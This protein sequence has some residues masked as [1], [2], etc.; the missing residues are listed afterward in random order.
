MNPTTDITRFLDALSRAE[1]IESLPHGGPRG[2]LPFVTI[3]RQGGAGGHTLAETLIKL[4]ERQ[5]NK[6]LFQGWQILDRQL[7]ELLLQD[8]RLDV[9]MQSLLSEEY[10]SQV[11]EFV[12]GLLG[13][14]DQHVAIRKMFEIIRSLASVGKVIIVGRG[15]SHVTKQLEL[16]VHVRLVAPEY[17][18]IR[19]MMKLL[20]QDEDEARRMVRKQDSDRARLLKSYFQVDIDDPL[21]YHVV[22]NTGGASFEVIAESIIGLVKQRVQDWRLAS[23]A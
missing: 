9:S 5:E 20:N 3:S 12:R 4:M 19:R 17:L 13:Q 6:T 2:A 23:G 11:R 14:P 7:C 22:W 1:Q 18:R 16:G 15:G 8:N 21:Q 10:R